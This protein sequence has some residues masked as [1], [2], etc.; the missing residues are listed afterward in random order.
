MRDHFAK[1]LTELSLINPDLYLIYGDIGNRLF[2]DFKAKNNNHFMN[3]GIAEASMVTLAAGLAKFGYRPIVYTI[4][5]F[6]YLKAIEQIK[7][8]VCY[9]NLPVI[10]V[11]TGSALS[12]SELGTTHH[13]LEDFGILS[14]IP[15]L[16][17]IS[18]SDISEVTE[19]LKW[20]IESNKPTYI[21]LGKK[22]NL[23]LHK[24]SLRHQKNIFG[25]FQL[26][27]SENARSAILSTG[28]ITSEAFNAVTEYNLQI[29]LW[30]IPLVKPISF[31]IL[32]IFQNYSRLFVLEEH[33]F[34]GGLGSMIAA[35]Y[36]QKQIEA[37]KM[38]FINTGDQFH[39][40][41]GSTTTAR[42]NLKIDS[43]NLRHIL[44]SYD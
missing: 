30:S 38:I 44:Q 39:T 11:G 24:K 42:E 19:S 27:K 31:N 15:N 36:A 28:A 34:F 1:T 2:D 32:E 6:L 4:N 8:D 18:P 33:N 14:T 29:D 9:P 25:P 22:E 13:S 43:K 40:G 3:A 10:L 16:Q 21:R 12:Y 23:A 26:L 41:L 37:P 20:A 35:I 7:I 17:I 5:S